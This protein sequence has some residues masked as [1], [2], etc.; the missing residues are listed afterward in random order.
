MEIHLP[1]PPGLQSALRQSRAGQA[2]V[3]RL[4]HLPEETRLHLALPL[5]P[6]G[7]CEDRTHRVTSSDTGGTPCKRA[8]NGCFRAGPDHSPPQPRSRGGQ[9]REPRDPGNNGDKEPR[10]GSSGTQGPTWL[11]SPGRAAQAQRDP[12]GHGAQARGPRDL[13]TQGPTEPWSPAMV[14]RDPWSHRAQPWRPW[15]QGTT[16]PWCPAM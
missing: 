11:W 6:P 16:E 9:A 14:P 12:Q 8:W 13:G 10:Q 15:I 2:R 5:C 7:S 3:S 4:T 1:L